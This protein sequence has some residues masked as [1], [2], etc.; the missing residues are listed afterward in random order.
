MIYRNKDLRA[1]RA[2][3]C[4]CVVVPGPLQQT[5]LDSIYVIEGHE[6]LRAPPSIRKM[7]LPWARGQKSGNSE[8]HRPCLQFQS[9]FLK[10]GPCGFKPLHSLGQK[11]ARLPDDSRWAIP[12]VQMDSV[13]K[14]RGFRGCQ[15]IQFPFVEKTQRHKRT[16]D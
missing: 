8:E 1:G 16:T 15:S 7:T 14:K 10:S 6:F 2:Q 5:E 4:G 11:T 9:P 3:C 13:R 12:A